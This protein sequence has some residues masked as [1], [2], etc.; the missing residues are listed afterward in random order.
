MDGSR[1]ASPEEE[2]ILGRGIA[3]ASATD[4]GISDREEKFCPLQLQIPAWLVN[5]AL[6]RSR[7]SQLTNQ[8]GGRFWKIAVDLSEMA[9]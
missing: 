3:R 7:F 1:Q 9:R 6:S 2:L 5:S 4:A 8:E